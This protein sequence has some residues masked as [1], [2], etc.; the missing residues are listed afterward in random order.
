MKV[1]WQVNESNPVRVID[2]FVAALGLAEMGFEVA[3]AAATGRPPYHS[4]QPF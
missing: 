4:R 1:R 2:V 3:K